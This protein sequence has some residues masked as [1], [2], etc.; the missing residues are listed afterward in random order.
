MVSYKP[1]FLALTFLNSISPL[2][3]AQPE[4]HKRSIITIWVHGT[5]QF[6]T[7]YFFKTFFFCPAG[8]HHINTLCPK[9]HAYSMAQGLHK[10]SPSE[11]PLE[12]FY[13]FGWSGILSA[14]ERSKAAHQLCQELQKLVT[15]Y[16]RQGKDPFIR[17]ITHSHGGNVALSMAAYAQECSF[18]IDELILLA[19][20]VQTLTA[21]YCT[22]PF[23]KQIYSL[24]SEFDSLQVLDPQGFH[25]WYQCWQKPVNRTLLKKPVSFFSQ[26]RFSEHPTLKQAAIKINNRSL[27][28]IEFIFQKFAHALPRILDMMRG[29]SPPCCP[30]IIYL[31]N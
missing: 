4:R 13:C 9:C 27:S 3:L 10:K 11:F 25:Y 7:K 1:L 23:F 18:F 28:H 19:C 30:H 29:F 2:M 31:N 21:S 16:K 20:P 17:L 5:R 15:E 22:S 26:R 12:S 14:Q 24:Y 8:L 6:F